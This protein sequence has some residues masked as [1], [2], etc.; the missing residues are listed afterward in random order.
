MPTIQSKKYE[1][2]VQY[3]TIET[4]GNFKRLGKDRLFKIIDDKDI[5]DTVIET[6]QSFI[7][8]VSFDTILEWSRDEL[9]AELDKLEVEYNPRTSTEKLN[10]LYLDNQ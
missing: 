3:I 1:D 10:Q 8:P 6:P 2:H 7:E 4:W 9:K 5:Q